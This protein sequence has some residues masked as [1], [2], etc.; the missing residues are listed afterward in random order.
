M[1]AQV[2]DKTRFRIVTRP[3]RD[4][5]PVLYFL[6]QRLF[7]FNFVVPGQTENSLLPFKTSPAGTFRTSRQHAH[8]LHL[9][10]DFEDREGTSGNPFSGT[11]YRVLN[12]V[13]DMPLRLD[14][15]LP[16]PE[17]RPPRARR[18]ASPSPWWSSR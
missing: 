17:E 12:F 7:P 15:W 3:G 8:E 14:D 1:A 4:I 9:D 18:G 10:P 2:Y 5:L 11:G 6:T 16:P 13:V